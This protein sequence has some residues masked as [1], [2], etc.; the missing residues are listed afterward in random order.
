LGRPGLTSA[1]VQIDYAHMGVPAEEYQENFHTRQVTLPVTVTVNASVELARMD[2]LPLTGSIPRS[3]WAK[4]EENTDLI[5]PDDYCLLVLDLRNAWPSHLQIHLD[6]NDGT[7]IDEEILPGNTSRVIFPIKRIFLE[8]P[9]EAIPALDPSRQRQF[10]VSTGRIS[11]ES[12]RAGREA[13]WYRE[14]I[15][16]MLRGSWRTK[17]GPSRKGEIELRAI[18]LSQRMIEA[19]KVDDVG[20]EIS[21]H[22]ASGVASHELLS[23]TFAEVKIRITNRS[24]E[25]I[26]PL[27]RI[28]P[29]VR[30]QTHSISLDLSKKFVWNGTLQQSLPK[31]AGRES[32]EVVVGLTTLCRGEFEISASV[33]EA[34]LLGGK[35]DDA[36]GGKR[37]RAN[38]KNIM[39]ALLGARERRIW[40]CR[41]PCLVV[42]RD[43][44]EDEDDE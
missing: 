33:E 39:D 41:E 36:E 14:E 16:K 27:I 37:Q 26:L 11:A 28:Q 31:L 13:F 4:N 25:P 38:T 44:D 29:S 3:L 12:E 32:T 5:S 1:F 7:T 24:P 8:N 42:V 9:A 2:I 15:L 18:R 40:C 6:V 34:R 19:V 35:V 21:V 43:E 23:D 17:S 10:V 30:N 20:I 22:D